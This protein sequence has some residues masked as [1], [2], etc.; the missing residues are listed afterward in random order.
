MFVVI[1]IRSYLGIIFTLIFINHTS[2]C[3]ELIPLL[4][5]KVFDSA[6]EESLLEL[7]HSPG[8]ASS[9]SSTT[10]SGIKADNFCRVCNLNIPSVIYNLHK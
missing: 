10:D 4:L 3:P 9:L 7:P 8:G 5:F 2:S 1:V 6:D